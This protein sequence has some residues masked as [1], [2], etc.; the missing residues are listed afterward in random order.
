MRLRDKS[1]PARSQWRHE[2]RPSGRSR[3]LSVRRDPNRWR[4]YLAAPTRWL[5]SSSRT[6]KV[7]SREDR[8]NPDPGHVDPSHHRVMLDVVRGGQVVI[9]V[10]IDPPMIAS[11]THL[12]VEVLGAPT[13]SVDAALRAYQRSLAGGPPLEVLRVDPGTMH[14]HHNDEHRVIQP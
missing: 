7:V 10:H 8:P 9:A 5:Y 1:R 14:T 13:E 4:N 6:G 3:E 12:G 11:L 2:S